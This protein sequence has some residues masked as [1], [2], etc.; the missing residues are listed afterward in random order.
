M[1]DSGQDTSAGYAALDAA[2]EAWIDA[3]NRGDAAAIAAIHSADAQ[4]MP[5][6]GNSIEGRA[7]I[8]AFWQGFI[9]T[10]V[11]ASLTAIE[12]TVEG[13]MGYKV[14]TFRIL[15]AGGSELDHGK[16]IEVWRFMDGKWQFHRDIWNSS[17]ALPEE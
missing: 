5:P 2:T 16:Y 13:D 11:K 3:F 10:G 15:D 1:T 14:G 9:D 8:Q 17:V 12:I 7:A 6:N 4:I